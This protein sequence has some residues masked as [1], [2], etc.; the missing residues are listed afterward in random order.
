MAPIQHPDDGH[1]I[2]HHLHRADPYSGVWWTPR[3]QL[4]QEVSLDAP[5]VNAP[6]LLHNRFLCYRND[7]CIALTTGVI[8]ARHN[9][10]LYHKRDF[11]STQSSSS[12]QEWFLYY[13][14]DFFTTGVISAQHNRFLYCG[15]H[16]PT[17]HS[18]SSLH[19]W[20]LYYAIDFVTTGVFSVLHN[21]FLRYGIDF[22]I[23]QSII[24]FL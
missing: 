3:V 16:F 8:P 9:R 15:C 14:I 1:L 21:R 4:R 23:T 12:L 24:C 17:T 5:R 2:R 10:F 13:A 18:I 6:R 19:E 7:F 11:C 20:F 22:C